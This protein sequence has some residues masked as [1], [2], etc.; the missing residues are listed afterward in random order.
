MQLTHPKLELFHDVR[1]SFSH[2]IRH[3]LKGHRVGVALGPIYEQDPAQEVLLPFR[4]AD[5]HTGWIERHSDGT[6]VHVADR[7]RKLRQGAVDRWLESGP[8]WDGTDREECVIDHWTRAGLVLEVASRRGVNVRGLGV[9]HPRWRMKGTVTGRFG[10]GSCGTSLDWEHG[11]N[12]LTIPEGKRHL[13]VP[14]TGGRMVCVMDFRAMDLCSMMALV[15]GLKERYGEVKGDP[16]GRTLELLWG[17]D[18][19]QHPA[20]RDSC[21]PEIFVHAYGGESK[22]RQDFERAI[23]ELTEIRK[24]DHDGQF[25][26]RVQSKSAEAFRAALSNALPDLIWDSVVPMFAVHDELV[27]DVHDGGV[28]ECVDIAGKLADGASEAIGVDY[29]VGPKFG[30]NYAEA[31]AN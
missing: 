6:P 25:A 11:F 18:P 14:R 15:P 5:W 9:V 30:L 23:P 19:Q 17:L 20:L 29:F 1:E 2:L 8:W 4:Q 12:P 31:K 26:R 10:A 13:V 21:K 3:A 24:N 22:V 7:V 27:L 16:H 28:E